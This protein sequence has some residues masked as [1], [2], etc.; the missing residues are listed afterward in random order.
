MVA[1]VLYVATAIPVSWMMENPPFSVVPQY[2]PVGNSIGFV[3]LPEPTIWYF[4]GYGAYFVG[5]ILGGF[6]LTRFLA[7]RRMYLRKQERT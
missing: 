3:P 6:F 7:G 4:I 5:L 1:F 2:Q